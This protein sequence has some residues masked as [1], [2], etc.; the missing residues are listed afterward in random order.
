MREIDD[1]KIDLIR[2]FMQV[3]GQI[4]LNGTCFNYDSQGGV[5]FTGSGLKIVMDKN[6]V[7]LIK[8]CNTVIEIYECYKEMGYFKG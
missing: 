5:E 6:Q 3:D 8:E 2:A 7:E 1:N 4:N